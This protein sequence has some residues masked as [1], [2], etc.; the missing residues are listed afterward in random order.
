DIVVIDDGSKES[1]IK[2]IVGLPGEMVHLKHGYVF[3]NRKML[4]EPYV[5]K[6]IY[7]FPRELEGGFLLAE[8]EYFV[9]GD[10]RPKSVDSRTYGAVERKQIKR[11]VPCPEGTI[12]P[13]FGSHLLPACEALLPHRT[14][15]KLEA[16]SPIFG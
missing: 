5:P 15:S 2:R 6:R 4:L 8:G 1:A 10:N 9:L 3:I 11:R 7:T 16:H 12:R 14:V 13:H